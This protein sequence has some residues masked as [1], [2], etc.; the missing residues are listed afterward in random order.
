MGVDTLLGGD[1][2]RPEGAAHFVADTFPR[3]EVELPPIYRDGRARA[4]RA[5]GGAAPDRAK[6]VKS[7]IRDHALVETEG[8]L[9]GTLGAEASPLRR[10]FA[11]NMEE[12]LGVMARTAL[13]IAEGNSLPA[14]EERY[15]AAAR[16]EPEMVETAPLREQLQAA[17]A[18]VGIEVRG[19]DLREAVRRWEAKVGFVDPKGFM[20]S[21]R[22]TGGILTR[23]ARDQ[24]LAHIHFALPGV[25]PHLEGMDFEGY[26]FKMV[27][28]VHYTGS[29][30]FEGGTHPDGRPAS[31]GLIEYNTD[32]PVTNIGL[33]HLV[34]HE[35]TP[36]HYVD[37][38]IAD[39]EWRAGRVGI[40][41][42]AHTMAT[43][44]TVLCE[45]WAQNALA[46]LHGGESGL[47]AHFGPDQVVQ[48]LLE[49]FQDAGKQNGSI[50]HQMQGRSIEE[51]QR[52]L[53]EECVLS[54][55]LVK[56]LSGSWTKHPV[57]GPMYG[58]AYNVGYHVVANAI[59]RHG[60][61]AVA[62]VALHQ[63]GYQDIQT[64]EMAMAS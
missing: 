9:T 31:R 56:K 4:L 60:P 33:W 36:G 50:L 25:G 26:T 7:F 53:R 24:L 58:P 38:T 19:G 16:R 61:L 49:R 32:H 45:G 52:H 30:A 23:T 59:E 10:Q 21:V 8:R 41:G 43:A 22:R 63:R 20:E 34:S 27:S 40:E 64:F 35:I 18:S 46:A 54:D 62:R 5:I 44:E 12:S 57:I 15:R 2:G 3:S 48:H 6:M 51:V 39:L 55:Q 14:Y 28:G 13:A 47:V 37:S 17:L 42:V 1:V 29:S 11:T